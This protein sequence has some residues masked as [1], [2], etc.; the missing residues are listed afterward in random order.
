MNGLQSLRVSDCYNPRNQ[1]QSC[2]H[3]EH[4]VC[5]VEDVHV[6]DG[7][8]LE[9]FVGKAVLV[10]D[11]CLVDLLDLPEQCLGGELESGHTP[12]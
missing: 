1:R 9:P 7:L 3:G 10:D 12:Y 8:R 6:N 11:L 5:R 4:S 2:T